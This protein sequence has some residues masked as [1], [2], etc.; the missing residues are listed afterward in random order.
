M[1]RV[2]FLEFEDG[3]GSKSC[4]IF[5][6]SYFLCKYF[7]IALFSLFSKFFRSLNLESSK[8]EINLTELG[9]D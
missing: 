2:L 4:C 3:S 7:N 8:V 9:I 6:H 1:E 5:N